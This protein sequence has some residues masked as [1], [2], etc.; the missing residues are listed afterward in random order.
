LANLAGNLPTDAH[1]TARDSLNYGSHGDS[2]VLD[3]QVHA[4]T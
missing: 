1:T 2:I 4:S 3:R